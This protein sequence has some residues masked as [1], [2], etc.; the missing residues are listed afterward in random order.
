MEAEASCPYCGESISFWLAEDGG[1]A[2]SYVEDCAVCCRPIQVHVSIDADGE[3][4]V[5]AQRLD[6]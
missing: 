3:G 6:D 2:Q 5:Y 1:S 4:S